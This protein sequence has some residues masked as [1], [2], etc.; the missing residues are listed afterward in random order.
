MPPEYGLFAGM[1]PAIVAALLFK[2]L[3][4]E[5]TEIATVGPIPS[6]LSSLSSPDFLME[7]I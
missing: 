1:V 4:P 6:T 7:T 5:M 2:Y 3:G